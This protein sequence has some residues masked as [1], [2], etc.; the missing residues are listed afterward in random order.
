MESLVAIVFPSA[1][2][3]M[4]E[5]LPWVEALKLTVVG[6]Q[7][8]SGSYVKVPEGPLT[9]IVCSFVAVHPPGPV[10]VSFAINVPAVL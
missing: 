10:I 2:S 9:V 6:L 8:E 7:P 5:I 3:Q 1:K 4:N